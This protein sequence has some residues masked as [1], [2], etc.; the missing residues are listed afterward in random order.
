M[1]CPWTE[2]VPAAASGIAAS[3]PRRAPKN[4]VPTRRGTAFWIER[5]DGA[6]LLRRRP[7]KGLLGGMMEVPSG[8]WAGDD[9]KPPEAASWHKL[10]GRVVHTFTHF[11]LELIV[12]K[13]K[14]DTAMIVDGDYRWVPRAELADEALPT[15][16]RK[17]V[18][19]A[20]AG[21]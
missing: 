18:A 2:H 16:M 3:L 7:D 5:M 11:R 21:C 10:R 17:V 6:V 9:G 12:M 14:A 19:M 8:G 4:A 1:I 20:S 15:V 13:A